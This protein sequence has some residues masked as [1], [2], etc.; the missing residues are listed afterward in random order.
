MAKF[1]FELTRDAYRTKKFFKFYS[2]T[3]FESV[4]ALYLHLKIE[5][6]ISLVMLTGIRRKQAMHD[7]Y[8]MIGVK[9]LFHTITN[10]TLP[11]ES[12][13]TLPNVN[14]TILQE[15]EPGSTLCQS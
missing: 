4:D 5:I 13:V 2:L 12:M 3:M 7:A 15:M 8:V 9:K 10:V 14:F 1:V 11:T 6:T